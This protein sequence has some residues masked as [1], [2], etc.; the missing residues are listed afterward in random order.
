MTFSVALSTLRNEN[1]FQTPSL[2]L[3]GV[4][5]CPSGACGVDLEKYEPLRSSEEWPR[6]PV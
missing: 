6:I 2:P 3:L 1:S 4:L 5:E